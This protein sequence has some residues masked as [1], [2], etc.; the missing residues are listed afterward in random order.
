MHRVRCTAVSMCGESSLHICCGFQN[1]QQQPGRQVR[2]CQSTLFTAAA[3]CL[4]G[5]V[6]MQQLTPYLFLLLQ[7]ASKHHSAARHMSTTHDT[8]SLPG[9][10]SISRPV[11]QLGCRQLQVPGRPICQP[12]DAPH[13]PRLQGTQLHDMWPQGR[14]K[15]M[16]DRHTVRAG[17][18]GALLPSMA[19]V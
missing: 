4:A 3:E 11:L 8:G 9:N 5:F 16:Q 6:N 14:H 2:I 19:G 10:A 12:A 7:A 1:K 15:R 13:M 18:A 17:Q